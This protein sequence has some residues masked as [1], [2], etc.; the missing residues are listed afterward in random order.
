MSIS[1][2]SYGVYL[3][4][5]RLRR[6]EYVNAL[7]SCSADI[8]EKTVM[9]V[10]E[11]T[12]TMAVEAARK[13]VAGLDLERVGVLT[14]A[15]TSYPYQEK[16]MAGTIVEALGLRKNILTGHHG[17]STLA[18]TEAFLSA[19]GLLVGSGEKYALVIVSDA[20]VAGASAEME[21]SFGA[22]AC[23]FVLAA[24]EQGL[25]LE[26]FYSCVTES[27]GLRFR[28][29]GEKEVRDIGVRTYSNQAYNETVGA[30]VKGLLNKLG[31]KPAG[32][33]HVILHQND[34]R[35]TVALAKKLGFG[36]EQIQEGLVYGQVGDT[37][38]C[39]S[40]LGLCRVLEK[41]VPGDKILVGSYGAGGASQALSFKLNCRLPGRSES[42]Q[43]L[44]ED[45]KY[46]SYTHYLK[47]KR[48][49]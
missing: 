3:P 35:T 25:E 29:A 46:I 24:D 44:L 27:L 38:A 42:F 48:S 21:H 5:L 15:S 26:G 10:D 47:L 17:S 4:F 28:P 36:D 22:A 39:S 43:V 30:A 9:D 37:G 16:V 49:I 19:A 6:E 45:K 12:M 1:V 31:Q 23:A 11:D 14:L 20:P 33:R 18:G 8:K 41:T 13:A 34:V 32:Y 40:L 7:G 2:V